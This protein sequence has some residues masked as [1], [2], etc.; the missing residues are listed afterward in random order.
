MSDE[1]LFEYEPGRPLH[2]GEVVRARFMWGI[3]T[4]TV[5]NVRS[6]DGFLLVHLRTASG[7]EVTVTPRRLI[8]GA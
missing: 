3:E 5:L 7:D 4:A 1:Y 2:K 6:G 8:R